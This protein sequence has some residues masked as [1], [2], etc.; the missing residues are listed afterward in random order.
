[1]W[2]ILDNEKVNF[3][4]VLRF[5]REE[6]IL[7]VTDITNNT[8]MIYYNSESKAK[9]VENYLMKVLNSNLVINS[10]INEPNNLY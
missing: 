8:R 5:R 7:Y 10:E 6:K 3:N 1:M 9:Q 4:L 2:I